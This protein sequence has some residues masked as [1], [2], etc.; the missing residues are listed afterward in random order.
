[1]AR[2]KTKK[3]RRRRTRP[4]MSG[5]PT[6][7]DL[8]AAQAAI[9]AKIEVAIALQKAGELEQA[10][11]IYCDVLASDPHHCDA[12]HLLGMTLYSAGAYESALE[13]LEKARALLG[14]HPEVI[15]NMAL[16]YHAAGDFEQAL[17]MLRFVVQSEPANAN[18]RNNLGV[19]LLENGRFREAETQ[20]A[21]TLEIQ[22]DFD[23]A[24]MNLAN[25]WVRQNRL[26]DAEQLYDELLRKNPDDL[27]VLGNLGECY[28]RQC[29]WDAALDVLQQVVRLRPDD[30]VSQITYARTLVN[31]GR[32]E[33]AAE[34]FEALVNEYPHCAKARHY[35]G[36]VLLEQ[37]DVT[38]AVR[39][40]KRALEMTPDDA[41]ALCSL[42]FAYIQSDRRAD[43]AECFQAA[44]KIDPS[45]SGAHGCLLY[46]MSGDP[47]FSP[48]RVFEEHVRWGE[49]HGNVAQLAAHKNTRDPARRLRIGYASADFCEHAV[50][51]FFEPLLR[52]RNRDHFEIYCYYES[53]V[54]DHIT[55][56]MKAEAD[57]W[58]V[59]FGRSDQ[60]VARQILDDQIDILVDLAGHTVG[61]RLPAL[62]YKPAPVQISWLGYPNTTGL[63]AID[64]CL[65]C[66]VQ[67]PVG[68]PTLHTED[69]IRIPGGS[70]CFAPPKNAPDVFD[71]PAS[72][73]G[74]VT[75]GSLHRPFK[76]SSYTQDLWAAALKACPNARLLAFNTYFNESLKTELRNALVQRGVDAERIEIRN[77][78]RGESYLETYREIDIGLDATPWAG[79]TTT[80]EALW[81]GV[82]V[83][84]YYG[85]NR[86]SRG[87]AGIVHHL[88]HPDWI[89][90]TKDEYSARLSQLASDLPELVRIRQTL[91][92][93]TRNTIADEQRFVT[94]LEQAYRKV[95]K[96]W[97]DQP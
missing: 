33:D 11:A 72:H 56:Q 27:D 12:W 6:T 55:A 19:F 77:T 3:P 1:M 32:L 37:D 92:E 79:G 29:K 62:A 48:E 69:L 59:T 87:T 52:L 25:C 8:V 85:N 14:D 15:G 41:H 49:I 97:C 34:R 24:G 30:L 44:L 54:E 70:F 61:N 17:E 71:L 68:E 26:H 13:C 89:A 88:G 66:D 75:F 91:R 31:L 20:L 16:V 73:N 23:Q 22:P 10:K 9:A 63:K 53:G 28:R 46:L 39:E 96:R 58:R 7:G 83:I 90:R 43:A 45:M 47:A 50:A 93:Q 21:K 76:I 86:P 51:S 36:T 78:Y 42:G 18:A 2:S 5:E 4:Q 74:F 64:Y 57:H 40:I 65:T 95:W 67:N 80:M 84:G 60:Q 82:P 38:G 94:E 35:L 81:M